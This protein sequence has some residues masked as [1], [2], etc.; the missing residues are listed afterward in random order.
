[1]HE[2]KSP[3]NGQTRLHLYSVIETAM[4]LLN[5]IRHKDAL[6]FHLKWCNDKIPFFFIT[7]DQ[8]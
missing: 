5:T 7:H 3:C 4:G 8:Y 2:A 6:F 1:M